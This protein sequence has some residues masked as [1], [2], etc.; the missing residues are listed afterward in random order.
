MTKFL[1]FAYGSN[2]LTERLKA[3]CASALPVGIAFRRGFAISFSKRSVDGSGK[4]T[5]LPQ[6]DPASLAWG[7]LFEIEAS[8]ESALSKAEGRDYEQVENFEVI[9][10]VSGGQGRARTYLA[11]RESLDPG[12]R[13]Y[14]WYLELVV[15]GTR[16]HGLPAAYAERLR[17][18]EALP[19]PEPERK[20]RQEA[21]ALLN[22]LGVTHGL[23]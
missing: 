22:G 10:D 17:Q 12:L 9:L 2:M 4:A 20:G 13:P 6:S 1:Y 19:D 11:R 15:A 21:I 7:V 16:Q 8:Q 5:L 3:R 23:V 14:D 18:V